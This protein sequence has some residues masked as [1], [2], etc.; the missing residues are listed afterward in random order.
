MIDI[1]VFEMLFL[2]SF[3]ITVWQIGFTADKPWQIQLVFTATVIVS[4]LAGWL[5]RQ[6]KRWL[7]LI[8]LL[9]LV[10]PW[11]DQT[12]LRCY[13]PIIG[14]LLW[15]YIVDIPKPYDEADYADKLLVIFFAIVFLVIL[16]DNTAYFVGDSA[17]LP[18]YLP[19]L[20]VSGIF[21]LRSLRHRRTGQSQSR[22]RRSNLGYL[23]VIGLTYALSQSETVRGWLR[24]AGFTVYRVVMDP[25]NRTMEQITKWLFQGRVNPTEIGQV[26]VETG[27]ANLDPEQ[28]QDM[29]EGAA[30]QLGLTGSPIGNVLVI[31]FWLILVYLVYR[32]FIKRLHFRGATE[33]GEDI[34]E[35]MVEIE[36]KKRRRRRERYPNQPDDQVRYYYRRYLEKLGD[37]WEPSDTSVELETK[38]A[39][40]KL[41]AHKLSQIYRL[42]RY[43]G[44][45]ADSHTVEQMKELWQKLDKN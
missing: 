31:L 40:R 5:G 39:E 44:Q 26:P 19:L 22:I 17:R 43:G 25:F 34:R 10:M 16:R 45:A 13:V 2:S 38:A 12:S 15:R 29:V 41:D 18:T 21:F 14:L 24:S 6:K 32:V 27:Q 3:L 33:M 37:Q 20:F 1:L 30:E 4:L 23:V 11:I 42:V 28:M 35:Q 36:P 8:L 7:W 9:L